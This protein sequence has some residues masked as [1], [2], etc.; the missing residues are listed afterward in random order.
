LLTVSGGFQSSVFAAT[1][2]PWI[3]NNP[4]A[5]SADNIG[6]GMCQRGFIIR[7]PRVLM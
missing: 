4:A 2:N 6:L 7:R 1:A 5:T 3:A